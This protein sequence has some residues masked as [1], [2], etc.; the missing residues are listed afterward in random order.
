[1]T[2]R[3]GR[4]GDEV[5]AYGLPMT[6]P[7]T[8]GTATERLF[9]QELRSRNNPKQAFRPGANENGRLTKRRMKKVTDQFAGASCQI[10]KF[11]ARFGV[12]QLPSDRIGAIGR[13]RHP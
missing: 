1:M 10:V 2:A 4:D 11:A 3:V 8:K 9:R 12:V 13:R 7:A 6:M 5:S